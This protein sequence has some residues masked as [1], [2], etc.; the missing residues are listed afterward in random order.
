MPGRQLIK[1]RSRKEGEFLD[2]KDP[3]KAKTPSEAKRI[4]DY[5]ERVLAISEDA[6]AGTPMADR[7]DD[8]DVIREA[9]DEYIKMATRRKN[10]QKSLK[11]KKAELRLLAT[12][13]L[14]GQISEEG[15]NSARK[16]LEKLTDT[17][18][19]QMNQDRFAQYLE[20]Y[21]AEREAH[22]QARIALQATIND[23]ELIKW[24]NVR[25]FLKL[26]DSFDKMT[27]AQLNQLDEYLQKFETGDVFLGPKVMKTLNSTDLAGLHTYR[28]VVDKTVENINK[29]RE[30]EG[31]QPISLDQ[32][33]SIQPKERWYYMG[34]NAL[35]RQ[36]PLFEV[37]I[38]DIYKAD[39][40]S[41][42]AI[43]GA[44]EE[45]NKLFDEARKSRKRGLLGRLI[46]TDERIFQW[47]EASPE[48]K[49]T[50]AKKMTPEEIKAAQYVQGEF[51]KMRDD[52]IKGQVLKKYMKNY[53]THIRRSFL[54]AWKEEGS[55]S[56]T[57]ISGKRQ[58]F[59][60]RAGRGA[61]AAFKELLDQYKQNE[62]IMNILDAKTS[63][64]LPLEKWFQFSQKR[65]GQLKPS[66]NVARAFL[67][68]KETFER[69]RALDSIIPKYQ[70]IVDA[71]SPMQQTPNGLDFNAKLKNFYKEFMNTQK[72]RVTDKGYVTPGGK[73]DWAI[74][75][76][77]ALTRI[78]AL[79]LNI[80]VGLT[81][82]VGAQSVVYKGLGEKA[83]AKGLK[84]LSTSRGRK[85]A[86]KY[87][88]IIGKSV[89]ENFRQASSRFGDKAA[90]IL[91]GLFSNA[92]RNAKMAFLLGSMTKE[93]WNNKAIDL[94]RLAKIKRDMGKQ[95]KIEGMGTSSIMGK[96]AGGSAYK[97]F[98]GWA[99]PLT[100]TTISQINKLVSKKVPI[101]SPE[102]RELAR[103]AILMATLIFITYSFM[104]E[105]DKNKDRG[106]LE[107]IAF[108]AARDSLSI[109]GALDPTVYV[110]SPA[111]LTFLYNIGSG[112]KQIATFET[113]SK[114][115]LKGVD[116]IKRT[117][118][119][120]A[121]KK[122]LPKEKSTSVSS[123]SRGS[124]PTRPTRP[125]RSSRPT[126]PTRPT[127]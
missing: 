57:D 28:E 19:L 16:A 1:Y 126:R 51:Q 59:W 52:L 38:H 10:L 99:I 44:E 85:L 58:G 108:K 68:Y 115:N 9:I 65:S 84:R 45:V 89:S 42:M 103:S 82:Q 92:D 117:V 104:K 101:N 62:E 100:S 32:L 37:M 4:E 71:L 43:L 18:I 69:K 88:P 11:E 112:L 77:T 80:P 86:K 33:K 72:G 64:V 109:I 83:Y 98:K 119:P 34:G 123:S 35:V 81:S 60:R 110:S 78:L 17:E 96:T 116:T 127:R 47:I 111:L 23:K 8:P 93:E 90:A 105:E 40:E 7:Y 95:M 15:K 113:T 79:G 27:P 54:E 41:G 39:I 46:P 91:Y 30:S 114:G 22:R 3:G 61:R 106:F 25:K 49:L 63:Q 24:E 14:V 94:D 13:D 76:G 5:N 124:R 67:K 55:Y 75:S 56:A 6:F 102:G 26:P 87:E 48:D 66:K 121:I 36:N 74:R 2:F 107:E 120:T 97:Q 21:L 70:A 31:K 122:V 125:E 118:T 12:R 29:L 73:I 50:L 53:V 20:G